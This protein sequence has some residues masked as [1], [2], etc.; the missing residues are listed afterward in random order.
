MATIV[1]LSE[2][3]DAVAVI[4][5]LAR[6]REQVITAIQSVRNQQ[7]TRTVAIVCVVNGRDAG[8]LVDQPGVTTVVA[9]VNLGF[10][11]AAV[12]EHNAELATRIGQLGAQLEALDERLRDVDEDRARIAAELTAAHGN[13]RKRMPHP[14]RG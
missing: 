3:P 7:T 8:E 4:A 5:T 11:G 1:S 10:G 2:T 6:N 9:G 13:I 14:R 12:L